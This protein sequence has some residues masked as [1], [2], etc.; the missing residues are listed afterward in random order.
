[1]TS[2]KPNVLFVAFEFPPLASGGV[3]RSL[4]FVKYLSACG[5][6]PI[7]VT[8]K[9]EDLP[10]IFHH[11]RTDT[12]LLKE[13]PEAT[14]I[15][16][17]HCGKPEAPA[18]KLVQWWRI[19]SS[20]IE[21]FKKYWEGPLREALP[22]IIERYQ[23]VAV[24]VTIP[25]FAMAP[26]WV[27]LLKD[28]SLPLIID[29]RDA[30]SQWALAPNGSYWH[31]QKKKKL[32][33]EVLRKAAAVITTSAQTRDDLLKVHPWLDPAKCTVISNGY[34][35]NLDFPDT[36]T[37]SPAKKLVI[38]YVGN[39]Y[40]S[41]EA[42]DNIF[43][44]WWKKRP[45]RMLNYVPRKEDWLYRSPWFFFQAV[46]KLLE[47]QP[48]LRDNIEIRFAGNKPK[49]MDVQVQQAGLT[50][51]VKHEGFLSHDD[52][53]I[54][55][56]SCDML[57]LTSAKVLG[58]RDYSIAGKTFEYFTMK[59]PILGFVCEG[60]QKDILLETGMSVICDPDKVD[61]NAALLMK[62]I[63]EGIVLHPKPEALNK[64]HRKNLAAQ[65]ACIIQSVS[66]QTNLIAQHA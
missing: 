7:V 44:P 50:D 45:N 14:I 24:Y 9:E 63:E 36:L 46:K 47:L 17:V 40:Y 56:Q 23:P 11:G 6:N 35:G 53:V 12:S 21:N 51:L 37:L 1:M 58:G 29:F 4:Y 19:Y 32:E 20:V 60:A 42:R 39:F 38:G 5:V 16:R 26:L 22:G 43:K 18:N 33:A 34:D 10:Q 13:I 59:K 62:I 2:T 52:A 65:L 61:N 64:Y 15:E 55:Q 28:Y 49:W 41:P 48:S 31:F 30:W 3:Q 57:L 54:F 8:P 66:S 27:D 25:P